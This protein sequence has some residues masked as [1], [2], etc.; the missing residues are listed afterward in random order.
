[1]GVLKTIV[2]KLNYESFYI[3]FMENIK[4]LSKKLIIL[5]FSHKMFL[6]ILL[7]PMFLEHLLIF[8]FFKNHLS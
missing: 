8:F 1:M 2:N 5:S 6:K 7:N 3:N 4:K